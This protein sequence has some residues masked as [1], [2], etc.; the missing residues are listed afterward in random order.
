M[1]RGEG[2]EQRRKGRK[3]FNE[4]EKRRKIFG[5]VKYMISGREE[6]QRRKKRKK[7]VWPA[8]EKKNR[9]GKYFK[10]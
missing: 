10:K 9:R 2:E 6:E 5:E 3:M 8:E 4:G 1:V 7:N